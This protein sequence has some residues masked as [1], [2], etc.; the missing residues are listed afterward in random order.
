V[1]GWRSQ[2]RAT[3]KTTEV[4]VVPVEGNPLAYN[5]LWQLR[6]DT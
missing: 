6:A 3:V 5:S 4:V 2:G 1:S